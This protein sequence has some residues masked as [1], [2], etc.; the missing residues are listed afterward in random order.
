MRLADFRV[1][2]VRADLLRRL[3]R[4]AEVAAA[5]DHAIART[6][7]ASERAVLE[8]RRASPAV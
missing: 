7:N 6:E 2:Q 3:G 1:N 4:D 5:C 8:S